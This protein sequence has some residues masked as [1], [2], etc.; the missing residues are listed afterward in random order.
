[1]SARKNPPQNQASST[2]ILIAGALLL[3]VVAVLLVLR[4]P[5]GGKEAGSESSSRE[6]EVPAASEPS[7]DSSETAAPART[8]SGNRGQLAKAAAEVDAA[9]YPAVSRV[10][11]DESLSVEEAAAEL[12]DVV[13]RAD[14]SEDERMEALAHGL[15]LDFQAFAAVAADPALPVPLAE[16]YFAELCNQNELPEAQIHGCLD[17]LSHQN[18]EIRTQAAGQLAFLVGKEE[19][20]DSPD[21]L[22]QAAAERL[23]KLHSPEPNAP[24]FIDD[25]GEAADAPV[26]PPPAEALP[27]AE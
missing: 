26:E 3:L 22:R 27:D 23:A 17:L 20:A 19:L 15:N 13:Q 18:E 2:R 14:L 21:A 25:A 4:Q 11:G 5:G 1:M 24:P 16:R 12:L 7:D 8:R 6:I 10:L 9:L